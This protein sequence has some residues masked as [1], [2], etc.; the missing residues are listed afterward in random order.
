M[1]DDALRPSKATT[2]RVGWSRNGLSGKSLLR[3]LTSHP[4]RFYFFPFSSLLDPPTRTT[5]PDDSDG[6]RSRHP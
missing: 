4:N 2:S 3:L 1:A 6:K 5:P